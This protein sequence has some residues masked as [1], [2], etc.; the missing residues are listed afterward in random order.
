[1]KSSCVRIPENNRY[2]QIHEW[3]INFCKNSHCAALLL[4]FFVNWHDWK[5]KNDQ[6]YFKAN[7]ISES[8]GDGRPHSEKAYLFFTMEDFIE[9]TMNFYGKNA[10]NEALQLLVSL[11]V[12]TTHKN[13]NPRYYFD[14]TKYFQ[15]YPSVCN[16]WIAENYSTGCQS[17][18]VETQ[19]NDY[20]DTPKEA[21]RLFINNRRS[22]EIGEPVI[23]IGQPIT[24]TTN[25][26]TNKNHSINTCEKIL[27]LDKEQK[28]INP[29]ISHQVSSI[30]EVLQKNGLSEKHFDYPDTKGT[31][32]RLCLAGATEEV[33]IEAFHLA[34][35][36]TR[37]FGVNYLAKIVNDLIGT[38]NK[39][40]SRELNKPSKK[41]VF[42]EEDYS[43]G[44][45]WM[46]DLLG[47]KNEG[48]EYGI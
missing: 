5:L 31:I 17:T 48:D 15:F 39:N 42:F 27:S 35:R 34:S 12:L 4:S 8:H 21:N 33:F 3:Q 24:N 40:R 44:M 45:E 20:I 9:G 22:A 25:K 26:T 41:E 6:Y 32:E 30:I 14:K 37:D 7:N 10:I 28:N 19:P 2:I 43:S 11:N 13:P 16:H 46:S 1:M 47:Y 18:Q 36:N 38:K 29:G 23:E